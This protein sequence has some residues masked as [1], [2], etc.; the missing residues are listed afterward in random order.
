MALV[1]LKHIEVGLVK[2]ES[3]EGTDA[4]PVATNS[5]QLIEPATLAIGAEVTNPRPDLQNQLLDEAYPLPP[6]AKYAEISGRWQVRGKGAAY[7]AYT[8]GS[9][10]PEIHP[11]L[12]AA[13]F[14]QTGSFGAGTESWVYDS[15]ST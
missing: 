6:S 4:V 11:I 12:A 14:S 13:G 7:A 1:Q 9:E 10:V 8:V 3:T 2:I 15:A 5:I